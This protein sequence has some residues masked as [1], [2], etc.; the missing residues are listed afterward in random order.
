MKE[1]SLTSVDH[2][3]PYSLETLNLL[4]FFKSS[5]ISDFQ[6]CLLC[7][8]LFQQVESSLSSNQ[9]S[10]SNYKLLLSNFLDFSNLFV[11]EWSK[12]SNR[13][14][15][16][17]AEAE[18][19]PSIFTQNHYSSLFSGFSDSVYFDETY[20]IL[21]DRIERNG[22]FK[23]ISGCSTCLD[24]GCGGGR[25]TYAL[26]RLGFSKTIGLDFSSRNIA[27]SNSKQ[28]DFSVRFN[29]TAPEFIVGDTL[30]VA[31]PTGSFDFIFSNGVLHHTPN[32]TKGLGEI[33][34]LLSNNGI[35]FLYL[36]GA[37]GGIHWNTIELLRHLMQSVSQ[38]YA[39]ACFHAMGVPSNR[40]FYILDHIMVPF[41]TLMLPS[42]VESLL[43]QSGFSSFERLSRGTDYDFA[44]LQHKSDLSPSEA[45]WVYGN[46]QLR[47]L[48][49]K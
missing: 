11:S 46:A 6:R 35:C 38:K 20:S 39:R 13:L 30:D 3:A 24:L 10:V 37:P 49:N 5:P 8:L 29:I 34:R 41:N 26:S 48:I 23:K 17:E 32:I 12:T 22:I 4:S 16:P 7:L 9:A 42:E 21:M 25:Y 44:E 19:D 31:L 18:T 33:F 36:I 1:L 2:G 14:N 43:N 27:H 40:I 45:Y 47:Y 15:N 28:K